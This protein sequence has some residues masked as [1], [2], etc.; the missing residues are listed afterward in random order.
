MPQIGYCARLNRVYVRMA[1]KSKDFLF[2]VDE[3]IP[4]G[5]AGELS[6]VLSIL[7]TPHIQLVYNLN[8]PKIESKDSSEVGI[9]RPGAGRSEDARR[10]RLQFRY[11]SF[12]SEQR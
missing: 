10:Q 6:I 1:M 2:F 5:T 8:A 4:L 7:N 3:R 12:S 11:D 9:F